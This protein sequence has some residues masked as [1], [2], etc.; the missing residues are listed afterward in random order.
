MIS[1]RY[2]VKHLQGLSQSI[3]NQMIS[4]RYQVKH[5][6]GLSQSI[7]FPLFLLFNENVRLQCTSYSFLTVFIPVEAPIGCPIGIFVTSIEI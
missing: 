5:L 7:H 3:H 4:N 6:Q 2:Q 1:N